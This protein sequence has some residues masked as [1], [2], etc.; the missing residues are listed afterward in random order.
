M[1]Q[2][3]AKVP[4]SERINI[5]MVFFILIIGT[6][7]G[8]PVYLVISEQVTGGIHHSGQYYETN[9][10]AMG[11]FTF[12]EVNGT[13][14]DVPEQWRALDGKKLSLVGQIYNNTEAS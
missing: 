5:R 1:T 14:N 3:T 13:I 10:K 8:W 2:A 7:L 9:L 4:L 12:D 11:N 6:V